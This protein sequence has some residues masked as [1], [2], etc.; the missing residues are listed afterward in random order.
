MK[1]IK[2]NDEDFELESKLSYKNL[3]RISLV[4]S[5][6]IIALTLFDI[7]VGTIL[8]GDLNAI[9][10]TAIERFTQLRTN[11]WLGLYYLD[12]LNM[13]TSILM[14]PVFLSLILLLKKRKNGV[15]S[16]S[17]VVFMI[18]T[19]IFI[20]NNAGI[21]MLGLSKS[22][23][24][25]VSSQKDLIAAAGESLLIKGAHGSMGAFLGFF[26]SMIA[27]MMLSAVMIQSE[28][29]GKVTGWIGLWGT[30]LL[31]VYLVLVTFVPGT[32]SIAMALAAPGG[33]MSLIW[34]ILYTQRLV[35]V[36][37]SGN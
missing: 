9:P 8:G 31:L 28:V 6:L 13:V 11:P 21:S 26:L 33:I 37:K 10:E 22:Y 4:C 17:L 5:I 16:L 15:L 24:E 1:M 35:K 23:A 14:I 25:A 20:S 2:K 36:L 27:S 29:F 19:T 18:G 30:A 32:E 7:V 12:V 3:L 34:M